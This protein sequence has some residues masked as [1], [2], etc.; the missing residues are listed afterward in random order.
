MRDYNGFLEATVETF[1][2]L[3]GGSVVR[4]PG[5]LTYVES[6]ETAGMPFYLDLSAQYLQPRLYDDSQRL[7][8]AWRYPRTI[9]SYLT[10]WS[11]VDGVASQPDEESTSLLYQTWGSKMTET[12]RSMAMALQTLLVGNTDVTLA[13][14]RPTGSPLS[15]EVLLSDLIGE[16]LRR[17]LAIHTKPMAVLSFSLHPSEP[18]AMVTLPNTA[19][20]AY[21]FVPV[22]IQV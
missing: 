9:Q 14:E 4:A 19:S 20:M 11:E 7:N 8:L 18:V 22:P 2:T 5:Q 3:C 13:A 1:V 21:R 6:P 16:G 17:I 10:D 15:T 12:G